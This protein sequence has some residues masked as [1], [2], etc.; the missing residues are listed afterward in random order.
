MRRRAAARCDLAGFYEALCRLFPDG[1]LSTAMQA[2]G[3]R[4]KEERLRVASVMRRGPTGHDSHRSHFLRHLIEMM[5]AMMVGMIAS[6]ALFLSA[7]GVTLDE[8]LRRHPVLFVVVQ[9][10][11]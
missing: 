9:A 2:S 4:G 10:F 7:A 3:P 1:R 8:G 6:A 5:L 11:G